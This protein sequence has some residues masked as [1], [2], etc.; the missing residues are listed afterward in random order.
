M[1]KDG[2]IV[3]LTGAGISK[4]SGLDTFRDEDGLWSKVRI[5]DVATYDAYKRDPINVLNF[6]NDRRAEL[7]TILA[8]LLPGEPEV[9]GLLALMLLTDARRQ[10]RTGPSGELIRLE[11]QD[12][13]CWDA[14]RIDEGRLLVE[15]TLRTGRVGPYQLQAAIAATHDQAR[16]AGETD[17]AQILGLYEVL[18]RIAPSPVVELNR[19]VALAMVAGP[20]AGLAA[21]DAI[22][23][24]PAMGGYRFF[25]AARADLLRRLD[26]WPEAMAAYERA[27]ALDPNAPERAFLEG[28]RAEAR[29][30]LI[31][32]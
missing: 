19:A 30:R 21:I 29:R 7:Y 4:E 14:A 5:E 9:Q 26:R 31:A 24:D 20:A 23:A 22:G 17:W 8:D 3:I 25:H 2:R 15:R 10:A 13:S 12:R 6:Y 28:R 18:A 27:L 32:S 16:T 11:E 1:R